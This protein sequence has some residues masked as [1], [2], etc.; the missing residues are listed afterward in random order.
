MIRHN[1]WQ[2]GQSHL[3]KTKSRGGYKISGYVDGVELTKGVSIWVF[4]S[5]CLILPIRIVVVVVVVVF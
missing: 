3:T 2:A 1:S 5:D 4:S